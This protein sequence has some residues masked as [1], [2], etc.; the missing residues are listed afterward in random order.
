MRAELGVAL[1]ELSGARPAFEGEPVRA[2]V[3]HV[4]RNL[5]RGLRLEEDLVAQRKHA[6]GRVIRG[7]EWR[8]SDHVPWRRRLAGRRRRR[9]G[10]GKAYLTG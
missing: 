1:V 5:E 7:R 10:R 9:A 8:E 3:W 6:H 2:R 4:D